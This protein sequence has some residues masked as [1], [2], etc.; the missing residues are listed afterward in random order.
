MADFSEFLT[1]VEV[2]ELGPGRFDQFLPGGVSGA[3]VG[4]PQQAPSPVPSP[5]LGNSPGFV[6]NV[7][8]LLALRA[9]GGQT[10]GFA[11]QAADP[12]FGP[13]DALGLMMSG[14][15]GLISGVANA[16]A[17]QS[18]NTPH[19]TVSQNLLGLVSQAAANLGVDSSAIG[20]AG[21]AGIG[22]AGE[23]AAGGGIGGASGGASGVGGA[24]PGGVA[25]GV[26]G[27]A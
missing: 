19:N 3:T 4:T 16:I 27:I 14:P 22:G 24:S 2:P 25:G 5:F 21:A 15:F 8:N 20:A 26:E 12:S 9:G 23:S 6:G 10:A 7:G 18:R 11:T 13:A 1:D 17:N